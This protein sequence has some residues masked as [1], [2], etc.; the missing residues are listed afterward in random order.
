MYWQNSAGLKF[1]VPEFVALIGRA[2]RQF[3]SWPWRHTNS[4]KTYEFLT[5]PARIKKRLAV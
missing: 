2:D 4:D 3:W 1:I 5:R